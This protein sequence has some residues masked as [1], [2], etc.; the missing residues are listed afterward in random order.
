[1]THGRESLHKLYILTLQDLGSAEE[2][3]AETLINIDALK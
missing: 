2:Q 1:M 3:I